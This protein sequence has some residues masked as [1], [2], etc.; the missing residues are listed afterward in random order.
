MLYE[1]R[2][3]GCRRLK[4]HQSRK[5][6]RLTDQEELQCIR[7]FKSNGDVLSMAE[8]VMNRLPLIK[9]KAADCIMN[10]DNS[11]LLDDLV[12]AGVMS[13]IQSIHIYNPEERNDFSKFVN[14]F[15]DSSM[16]REQERYDCHKVP[17][18][19]WRLFKGKKTEIC[20]NCHRRCVF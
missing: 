6:N 19:I 2:H 15:I 1:F 11:I 7:S 17:G 16:K 4:N 12:G 20:F 18:H 3:K 14:E 5:M 13:V 9:K 8:I 10:S